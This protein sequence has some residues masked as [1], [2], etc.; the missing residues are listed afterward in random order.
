VSLLLLAGMMAYY[1]VGP[2]WQFLAAP[3]FLGLTVLAAVGVGSLFAA[4]TVQYRDFRFVVPFAMQIWMFVSPVIYP[5][6][7]VPERWRTLYF[8]NPAAGFLDGFR[9]ACLDQSFDWP[10]L[11]ASM[12]V[13]LLLLWIGTRYFC[14]IERRLA[15]V[16]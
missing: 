14:T 13:T 8:L 12:A 15:D 7:I 4:L 10:R 2:T 16:I 5:S 3:L 1:G 11:V 6:A 9:A